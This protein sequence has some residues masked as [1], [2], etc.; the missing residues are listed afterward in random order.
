MID[1][2][3]AAGALHPRKTP[4]VPLQHTQESLASLNAL[5]HCQQP[6]GIERRCVLLASPAASRH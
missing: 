3:V 1:L 4:E 6:A 2:C 5:M